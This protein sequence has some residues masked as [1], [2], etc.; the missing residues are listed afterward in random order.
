MAKKRKTRQQ[1]IMADRRQ[2]SPQLHKPSPSLPVFQEA[3]E[4][5]SPVQ[6]PV[7]KPEKSHVSLTTKEYDY[8]RHDLIKTGS[9]TGAIILAELV[10]FFVL[11]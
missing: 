1:K 5:A 7:S 10:L 9:V 11:R 4:A 2:M 8:V 6:N 3:I